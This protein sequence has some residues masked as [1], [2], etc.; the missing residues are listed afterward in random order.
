MRRINPKGKT[1]QNGISLQPGK[2]P[3]S[4]VRRIPIFPVT[5]F[6]L[7]QHINVRTST[8]EIYDHNYEH[9]IEKSP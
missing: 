2:F 4:M 5:F 8:Q 9:T 1:C 7:L 6:G 3:L